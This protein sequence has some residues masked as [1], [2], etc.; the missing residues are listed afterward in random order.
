M[1]YRFMHNMYYANTQVL[2][3]EVVELVR[4]AKPPLSWFCIDAVAVNDVDFTAAEALRSVHGFLAEEGVRLVF[5]EV[6]D[7][8]RAELD[9]S[10]LTDLFGADAFFP[11]P[12]AV[13]SAFG[14]G[15]EEVHS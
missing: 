11:S 6:V 8:V 13:V 1:I 12:T 5:C 15:L 7:E 3:R 14:G 10:R 4:G 9:R 2:T